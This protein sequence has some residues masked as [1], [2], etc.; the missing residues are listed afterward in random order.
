MS[1]NTNT[2][3]LNIL[4]YAIYTLV[5]AFL[6]FRVG[7]VFYVNGAHYLYDIFISDRDTADSLN[8]LLLLGYY[9]LNLGYVAV[10]LS[11]WPQIEDYVQLIEMLGER[12]GIIVLGLGV[13]HFMNMA[14]VRLV[15]HY[16]IRNH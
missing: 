9:L 6:V 13:M 16:T 2:M 3:N 15:K 10:S 5:T 11:F 12:T 14:W 1:R 4:T 7:W 8:R